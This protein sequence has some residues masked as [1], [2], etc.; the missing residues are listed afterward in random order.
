MRHIEFL[1]RVKDK[2][3]SNMKHTVT[4]CV[5]ITRQLTL[6][7]IAYSE[8]IPLAHTV[9]CWVYNARQVTLRRIAYSEFIPLAHT[10]T[11]FT[12]LQLLPSTV[13]QLL[14]L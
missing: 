12:I 1:F 7:R 4:C 9:T 11:P 8:F 5:C 13:S 10:F 6:R 14:V 2:C 3:N